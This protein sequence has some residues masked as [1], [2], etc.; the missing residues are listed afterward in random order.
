MKEPRTRIMGW[1]LTMEVGPGWADGDKG[2][3]NWNNCKT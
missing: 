2:G 3:D 1:G